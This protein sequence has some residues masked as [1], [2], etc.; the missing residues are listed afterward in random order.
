MNVHASFRKSAAAAIAALGFGL[1][2]AMADNIVFWINSPLAAGP[3]APIHEEIKAFEAETG[4]TVEIQPVAHMEMERNLFVALSSGAGPDVMALDIAWVAGLADAGLLADITEKAAPLAGE[5]QAGPFAS[6]RFNQKQYALPLYTN[7][8]ALFVNDR[9]LAEAGIDKA[10]TNWQEFQEAAVAMTDKEK[11][12]YGLTFGG[13]R[14]GAFQIYSFIWQNDGEIIDENGE[15]R[16]GDPEAAGAVDFLGKLYTE[17]KAMPEAVLTAG[18]WD[19]VNAPF[20][21]E[22]AGMLVSGDWAL[23]ALEKGNPNLDFSV[24]P[25]PAGKKAATVIGGYDLA[26]NAATSVPDASWEL[27]RWLTGPRGIELMRKYDRL[28]AAAAATTPEAIAAL[29]E[30]LQPFMAQADAGTPRPVVASWSQIH[31][32]IIASAWD[33]VLRG[34]SAQDAMTEAA[35][36]I[37]GLVGQ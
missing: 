20:V 26:I 30:E 1:S 14:M 33:A 27:V 10:P 3:D 31:N 2:P 16:V 36:A 19:E 29:P 21:Q 6:G 13:G 7:N 34:K 23:G 11:G 12:T 22:R 35:T 5:F 28:S 32:E 15:V 37:K 8:V 4:H 24:H 25:L 17:S 9:M 18:S